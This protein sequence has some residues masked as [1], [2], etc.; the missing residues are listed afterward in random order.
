MN[1]RAIWGG[2]ICFCPLKRAERAANG[3]KSREVASRT[4]IPTIQSSHLN[5][6]YSHLIHSFQFILQFYKLCYFTYAL[7]QMAY[8]HTSTEVCHRK[9]E[10]NGRMHVPHWLRGGRKEKTTTSF[11]C[12]NWKITFFHWKIWKNKDPWLFLWHYLRF[13]LVPLLSLLSF[14]SS[15]GLSSVS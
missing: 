1:V 8:F 12:R 11:T 9:W 15:T 2:R 3:L 7:P 10:R 4:S 6:N 13:I 14:L 5:S